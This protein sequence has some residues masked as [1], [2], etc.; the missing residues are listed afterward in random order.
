MSILRPF[1]GL[2]AGLLLTACAASPEAQ[3]PEAQN[4]GAQDPGA[5]AQSGGASDRGVKAV[6]AYFAYEGLPAGWR[7]DSVTADD[8]NVLVIVGLSDRLW[9]YERA[10][11]GRAKPAFF[12]AICP[13]LRHP[14]WEFIGSQKDIVIEA[15]GRPLSSFHVS[16]REHAPTGA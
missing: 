13:A 12:S 4:P 1:A 10:L 14:V 3:G 9:A 2:L 6:E 8:D 11:P 15:R 5:A 7:L 16:C